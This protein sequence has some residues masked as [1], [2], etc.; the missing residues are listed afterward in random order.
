M[1][2]NCTAPFIII[3]I[4]ISLMVFLRI[5]VGSYIVKYDFELTIVNFI[6]IT[7]SYEFSALER[8]KH[9]AFIY[10]NVEEILTKINVIKYH[11]CDK[12]FISARTETDRVWFGQEIRSDFQLFIN[13]NVA[14]LRV[15]LPGIMAAPPPP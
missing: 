10:K 3:S 4:F 5:N 11:V 15:A 6:E 7:V 14:K 2:L 8:T 13:K 9:P 12:Y 1:F